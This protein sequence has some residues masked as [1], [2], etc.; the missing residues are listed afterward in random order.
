MKGEWSFLDADP[1]KVEELC[2]TLG[3]SKT[4]ATVLV[5]R[6][7]D[8]VESASLFL[9]A[10]LKS[11]L[12]LPFILI[13]GIFYFLVVL[14]QKKQQKKHAEMLSKLS[15]GDNVLMN[16]GIYGRVAEVLENDFKLEICQNPRVVIT[17]SPSLP[18]IKGSGFRLRSEMR[19]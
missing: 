13:F 11:L 3:I 15:K 2:K 12:L 7:I 17:P 14:P 5:N 6:K 19:R 4:V 9:Q 16:C 10:K 18:K 8:T 1:Y